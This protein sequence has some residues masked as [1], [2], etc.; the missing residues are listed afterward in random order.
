MKSKTIATWLAFLFGIFGVH[1]FYLKGIKDLWGWLHVPFALVGI[2]GLMRFNNLGQN[3]I[4]AWVLMPVFGGV[5]GVACLTAIVYGLMEPKKWN[6]LFNPG[7]PDDLPQART[8]WMAFIGLALALMIGSA[9]V[10]SSFALSF[11]A[12][13]QAQVE[14]GRRISQDF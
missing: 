2:V 9:A 3:D 7:A 4:V 5:L 10:L 12:Y 1:R 6:A 11:K 8:T 13:F 14:A